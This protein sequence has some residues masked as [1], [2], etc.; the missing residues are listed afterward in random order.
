MA[1]V[2]QMKLCQ[3]A[4]EHRKVMEQCVGLK[5]NETSPKLPG[6]H[7]NKLYM[8]SRKTACSHWKHFKQFPFKC[9]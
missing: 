9:N 6:F 4:E 2:K 3:E 1:A 7:S 5:Q 8:G